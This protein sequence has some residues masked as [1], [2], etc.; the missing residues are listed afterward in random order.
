[1]KTNQE[2]FLDKIFEASMIN[3]EITEAKIYGIKVEEGK[4]I[5]ANLLEYSGDVYELLVC[6]QN[7]NRIDLFDYLS[8]VTTGWAAPLNS[9]GE[10]DCAPSQHKERRRVSLVIAASVI[11]KEIL[12]SVVDFQGDIERVYDFNQ[13]T[14]SLADA[15]STLLLK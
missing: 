6:M 12:G 14:G 13:A 4:N 8:V 5:T 1:M 10:V 3:P 7:D 11:E 9:N 2:N 15:V